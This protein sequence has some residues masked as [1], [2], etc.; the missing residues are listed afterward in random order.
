MKN[1]YSD[2]ATFKANPHVE[3]ALLRDDRKTMNAYMNRVAFAIFS[4]F[5]TGKN[6]SGHAEPER[7][8]YGFVL[9]LSG[10]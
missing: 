7:F 6:S 3:R 9:G 4:Y 10:N 2:N 5:D 1:K 8:Y